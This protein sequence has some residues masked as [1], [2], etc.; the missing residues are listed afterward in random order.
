MRIDDSNIILKLISLVVI[1]G[2]GI[3]IFA[4]T[5][6]PERKEPTASTSTVYGTIK[7]VEHE[8][9]SLFI[10]Y[11]GGMLHSPECSKCEGVQK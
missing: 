8:G 1:V 11:Q 5:M 10:S 7:T 3:I 2:G 4:I 6:S 9:H